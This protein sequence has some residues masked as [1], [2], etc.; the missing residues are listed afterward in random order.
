MLDLAGRY[1]E[2]LDVSLAGAD[3]MIR[4]GLGSSYGIFNEMNA[5]EALYNMGRWDEALERVLRREPQAVGVARIL[6]EQRLA[7]LWAGRGDFEAARRALREIAD[8]LGAGTDAQFNGPIALARLE[9]AAWTGQLEAGRAAG[10]ESLAILSATD[11]HP[12]TAKVMAA[13]LWVE[14]DIAIAARAR[15]DPVADEDAR[16]RAAELLERLRAVTATAEGLV[17]DKQVRPFAALGEAETERARGDGGSGRWIDVATNFDRLGTPYPAAYARFRGAEA[18]LA[19]RANRSSV[20][21]LLEA[22]LATADRLGAVP[23]A[24]A[25]RAL[26]GRS[27]IELE[28]AAAPVE[29]LA[30]DEADG[31]AIY[32]LT[33]REIEVLRLVAA[34]RTNRQIAAELFISE[35]TAGVHVSHILAKLGVAGRVE[36]ATIASRL[37]LVG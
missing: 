10:E 1:E 29:A 16:S 36:A 9:V 13:A 14:A 32:D 5:V 12:A 15:R 19:E 6:A 7:R 11:D 20:G 17:L 21:A 28:H 33:T 27:R 3:L 30:E 8:R 18:A 4:S 24:S 23:L 31:I 26:A 35:S 37:G 25:I 22:A 2:S 34:G